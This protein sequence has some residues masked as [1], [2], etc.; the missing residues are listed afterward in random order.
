MHA[1][2]A[3]HDGDIGLRREERSRKTRRQRKKEGVI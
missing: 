2:G 1:R 3:D